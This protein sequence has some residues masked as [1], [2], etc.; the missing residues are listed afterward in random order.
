MIPSL[1]KN[2]YR[3]SGIR[4]YRPVSFFPPMSSS[5]PST[6]RK[7]FA[8]A[9]APV[10]ESTSSTTTYT[11]RRSARHFNTTVIKSER[12]SSGSANALPTSAPSTPPRKTRR[13][14]AVKTEETNADIPSLDIKPD[15]EAEDDKLPRGRTRKPAADPFSI[16][17]QKQNRKKIKLDLDPSEVKPAPKR[18][19]AQ[20]SVL[21][22]QRRRIVA[23]VDEM[24]CEENGTDAHRADSWRSQ[25]EDPETKARR[26]R[27]TCL[28]SLMLSSQTK[29]EITAAA[30]KNLQL[31]LKDGL[32][33]ESLL[34]ASDEE[35]SSQINKVGFWRRKTGYLKSAAH[36]IST[37]FDGDVPKDIDDLCSLP[38]VGPKMAFLC[39]QSAW[40]LNLGIGVDVH[41]HRMSNRLGWCKTND[42]ED[43]RL[44]LQSWLPKELHHSINKTLV[45]FGQVVCVP[46]GPR[47]DLCDLG[48]QKLCPSRRKVDPK[49]IA[50]RKVVEFLAEG[51]ESE[52]AKVGVVIE[53][54]QGSIS[55]EPVA[56]GT[57]KDDG[58][59]DQKV[60]V[61][62]LT[63]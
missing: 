36:I 24:G 7:L 47:C 12:D 19:E 41:V 33:L 23:P 31:N 49:S 54:P 59:G 60:K 43:T 40:G 4:A 11:L 42:P 62:Q 38:G 6:R 46:V 25:S 15:A 17:P 14:I 48:Q 63:W 5:P 9:P 2:T 1:I 44:V 29:D 18:W 27:F 26:E 34:A 3:F 21:Q 28:V 22:S 30:V 53:T 56:G 32:N 39:L 50:N 20:L 55:T 57:D 51:G 35:I 58:D 8:P 52:D 61:E 45:G 10:V 37:Q 13:S 16:S